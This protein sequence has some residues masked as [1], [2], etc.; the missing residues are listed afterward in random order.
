MNYL[1]PQGVQEYISKITVKIVS[2]INSDIS[3]IFTATN[4]SYKE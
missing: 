1:Y 3:K 4:F 2:F